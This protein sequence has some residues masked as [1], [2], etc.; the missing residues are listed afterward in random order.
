MSL[1][2]ELL[3]YQNITQGNASSELQVRELHLRASQETPDSY[4]NRIVITQG[5]RVNDPIK[6][7][8]DIV[9]NGAVSENTTTRVAKTQEMS[10]RHV[11]II[12]GILTLE[13]DEQPTSLKIRIRQNKKVITERDFDWK[14]TLT[15]EP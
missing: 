7:E 9:V 6:G 15:T 1:N 8:V 13:A 11:Q 12:E 14:A 5:Q 2:K 10:I 3:F 4:I